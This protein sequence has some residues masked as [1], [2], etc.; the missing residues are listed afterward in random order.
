ML[1]RRASTGSMLSKLLSSLPHQSWKASCSFTGSKANRSLSCP[2]LAC[3]ACSSLPFAQLNCQVCWAAACSPNCTLP[4]AHQSWEASSAFIGSNANCFIP[5]ALHSK[6]CSGSSSLPCA[7]LGCQACS[8]SS[9]LRCAQVDT[10]L[11]VYCSRFNDMIGWNLFWTT[12]PRPTLHTS[13]PWISS[14]IC[15]SFQWIVIYKSLAEIPGWKWPK[16]DHLQKAL[17]IKIAKNTPE[18]RVVPFSFIKCIAC[19]SRHQQ[20]GA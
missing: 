10:V 3:Q 16:M 6:A 2:R 4:S 15:F 20:Q 13:N 1:A 19:V 14:C 11:F 18:H 9:S 7:Q 12:A 5:R 8:G 17:P